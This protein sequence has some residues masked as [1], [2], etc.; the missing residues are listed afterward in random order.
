RHLV[1]DDVADGSS[2]RQLAAQLFISTNTVGVHVSRILAKL[3]VATRTEAAAFA[4]RHHL[5][6]DPTR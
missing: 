6:T 3:G 1:L 2:N 4:R 5:I